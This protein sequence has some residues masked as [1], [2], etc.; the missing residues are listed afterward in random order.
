VFII[1]A[2]VSQ[3]GF[4]FLRNTH[5]QLLLLSLLIVWSFSAKAFGLYHELRSRNISFEI[6][7]LA[8]NII[9]IFIST[10]IIL[11]LLHEEA[12]SRYFVTVFSLSSFIILTIEKFLFRN[13]LNVIRKKG[14]NLRSLLIVGAGD[15]GKSFLFAGIGY[16]GSCFPKD[17]NALIKTSIEKDST[18]KILRVVDEVNKGQKLV[19]IKKILSHFNNEIKDKAFAI[20]G[21]AFKP[22]TD[23][24]REAPS[25]SIISKLLELGAKVKAYDPAANE[26]A[27]FYFNSSIEYTKTD[28][29]ALKNAD[30]LLV[31][32]EWNEFR[33]P[34][35]NVLKEALKQ[36]VIF[37]GRNIYEPE[38]MKENGFTYY[39]IGREPVLIR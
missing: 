36:P 29:E 21:L 37:D 33:N 31:L 20:W 7:N 35:F 18:M 8:K 11:F 38:V 26:T 22:N 32:T 2:K 1:S 16:G 23:D 19:L 28:Y 17:V 6:I 4:N 10:I 30:A 13:I 24:M 5:A 14:R 15:V 9:I 39:S 27:H 25:I 34:D 3:P 12:L